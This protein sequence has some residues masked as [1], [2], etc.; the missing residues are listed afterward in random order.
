[1]LSDVW[2]LLADS[3]AGFS[4]SSSSSSG[5]SSSA[6][7]TATGASPEASPGVGDAN[8]TTPPPLRW[9]Q[10]HDLMLDAPRCAH[11]AAVLCPSPLGVPYL[12]VVSGFTG[13]SGASAMPDDIRM[14]PMAESAAVDSAVKEAPSSASGWTGTRVSRAIGSRFGVSVCNAA[15][16]ILSP[17][18]SSLPAT[19]PT[20][21]DAEAGDESGAPI[22]PS[23]AEAPGYAEEAA[24]EGF[25]GMLLFGGVNAERD[26]ADV[27]LIHLS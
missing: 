23:L 5:S 17:P 11:G 26:F 12:C 22:R 8:P 20:K 7:G 27:W 4:S 16:W 3:A 19:S 9:I 24:E 2:E 13:M 1:M 21:E 14:I 15:S 18:L 25:Q 6:A 10:R